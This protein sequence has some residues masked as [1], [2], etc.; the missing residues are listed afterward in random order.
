MDAISLNTKII[1]YYQVR[2]INHFHYNLI[3]CLQ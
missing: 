3:D 2:Q 1:V